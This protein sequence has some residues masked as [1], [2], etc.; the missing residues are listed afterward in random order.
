MH[1]TESSGSSYLPT[2]NLANPLNSVPQNVQHDRSTTPT[3]DVKVQESVDCQIPETPNEQH[4]AAPESGERRRSVSHSP[5]QPESPT[6]PSSPNTAKQTDPRPNATIDPLDLR[7][8]EQAKKKFITDVLNF[9]LGETSPIKNYAPLSEDTPLVCRQ[10]LTDPENQ[11]ATIQFMIKGINPSID[12]KELIRSDFYQQ[13]KGFNF[14]AFN[15]LL[16]P[17][18]SLTKEE[19][20]EAKSSGIDKQA[21]FT[22]KV[23][24]IHLDRNTITGVIPN[25]E[26]SKALGMN[27]LSIEARQLFE[28]HPIALWEWLV[29]SLNLLQELKALRDIIKSTAREI[30]SS[31]F[32]IIEKLEQ[33][34]C[35]DLCIN[36][37]DSIEKLRG[38]IGVFAEPTNRLGELV[39]ALEESLSPNEEIQAKVIHGILLDSLLSEMRYALPINPKLLSMQ[40]GRLCSLDALRLADSILNASSSSEPPIKPDSDLAFPVRKLGSAPISLRKI[41]K[42]NGF[43]L[44]AIT[45]R[46]GLSTLANA[47]GLNVVWSEKLNTPDD[48]LQFIS[49]AIIHQKKPVYLHCALNGQMEMT[50]QQR[51]QELISKSENWKTANWA[52]GNEKRLKEI[53]AFQDSREHAIII[54]NVNPEQRTVDYIATDRQSQEYP[55]RNVKIEKLFN[56][57]HFLSSTRSPETYIK[58]REKMRDGYAK[59]HIDLPFIDKISGLSD[60]CT[61]RIDIPTPKEADGFGGYLCYI[62]RRPD[63]VTIRENLL[64]NPIDTPT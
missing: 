30:N 6:S 19:K 18:L 40:S 58:T 5:E 56:A 46:S 62:E 31:K 7:C 52:Y 61:D 21:L 59:Y 17:H 41:A 20:K 38:A 64:Q 15:D 47:S 16:Y 36:N 37:E 55:V 13:E 49:N 9:Y 8:S 14:S 28:N 33:A 3:G 63:Y 45:D 10:I 35:S 29:T 42:E 12:I 51:L 23:K 44:G 22:N 57:N 24:D 53:K 1:G 32:E 27:N 34:I 43:P 11:P 39:E 4:S 26:T 25:T 54:F 50:D 60:R 48:Y 2:H